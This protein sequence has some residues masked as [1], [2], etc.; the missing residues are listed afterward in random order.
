MRE[1]GREGRESEK[2]NPMLKIS[3]RESEVRGVEEKI[4]QYL[5]NS[6]C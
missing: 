3:I 5:H 1:E 2:E 4:V 6:R